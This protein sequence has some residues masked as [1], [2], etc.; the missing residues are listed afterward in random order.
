M[1]QYEDLPE[2]Q[3]HEPSPPKLN[4]PSAPAAA[5]SGATSATGGVQRS[6]SGSGIGRADRGKSRSKSPTPES[7]QQGPLAAPAAA[8]GGSAARA[9]KDGSIGAGSASIRAGTAG[10]SGS[11]KQGGSGNSKQP[12]APGTGSGPVK[13]DSC[14]ADDSDPVLQQVG[15]RQHGFPLKTFLCDVSE[16]LACSLASLTGVDCCMC[17]YAGAGQPG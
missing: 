14:Q 12:A 10:S 4:L 7:L 2:V 1:S 11:S 8:G 6:R 17:L 15:P 5:A 9:G 3:W 16:W 13:P